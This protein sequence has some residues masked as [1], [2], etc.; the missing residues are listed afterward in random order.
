M[1]L[2]KPTSAQ[3]ALLSNKSVEE[4]CDLEYPISL[5]LAFWKAGC[6]VLFSVSIFFLA[7]S[8][9]VKIFIFLGLH[10]LLRG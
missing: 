4:F 5:T 8:Y 7:R 10:L 6:G 1:L 3:F 9:K 2:Q